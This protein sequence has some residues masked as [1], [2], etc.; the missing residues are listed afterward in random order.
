MFRVSDYQNNLRIEIHSIL[1]SV[2]PSNDSAEWLHP[3]AVGNPLRRLG[4]VVRRC[5][6][7]TLASAPVFVCLQTRRFRRRMGFEWRC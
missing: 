4:Q 3:C 5:L 7:V 1:I 2:A 6:T